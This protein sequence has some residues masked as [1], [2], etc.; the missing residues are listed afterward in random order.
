M[1]WVVLLAALFA[2]PTHSWAGEPGTAGATFLKLGAGPRAIGMGE[3]HTA[4]ADDVYA[5][6]WNP[7]GLAQLSY[8]ELALMYN[9]HLEGIQQQYLAYAHPFVGGSALGLN[10]TRLAVS[11]FDSYD[12]NGARTGSISSDDLAVG[13]AAAKA[14]ALPVE[15]APSLCA[16]ANVKFVRERLASDSAS[17]VATD[18]GLLSSG[19]ER[20]LGSWARGTKLGLAVRNLGPEMR[21][22]SDK[23]PLPTSVS[24]GFSV[25]KMLWDDPIIFA[26]DFTE[27]RDTRP[28][29]SLGA[30]YWVRRIL[31]VRV[32][33]KDRQD[34]GLGLRAGIGVRL[35]LVQLDYA[36]AGFGELGNTHR[37]G[38]SIRFGAPPQAPHQTP[39]EALDGAEELMRQ[40]R[41]YEAVL[42]INRVLEMDPSNARAVKLLR[43]AQLKLGQ[44]TATEGGKP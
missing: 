39:K 26:A 17:T 25:Q 36:F 23:T 6:Y 5:S 34:E 29:A 24:A 42:E 3:T 33:Y 28:T 22:V 21:F 20:W 13:L 8:R 32:G 2:A 12:N 27:G 16:G 19:W 30:E 10:L 4:V 41:T 9:Q 35:H 11:P 1:N 18:I 14:F 38:I 7:A 40:A 31:A 44:G 37:A 15:D 43:E